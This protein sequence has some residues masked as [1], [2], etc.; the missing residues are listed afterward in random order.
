MSHRRSTPQRSGGVSAAQRGMACGQR[1]RK[2]QPLGGS[3]ASG[4]LPLIGSGW[5]DWSGS[6]TGTAATSAWV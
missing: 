4:T 1:S 6:G 2:L 3:R 5:R